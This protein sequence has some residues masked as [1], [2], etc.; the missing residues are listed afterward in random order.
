MMPPKLPGVT[1]LPAQM[2]GRPDAMQI[3]EGLVKVGWQVSVAQ[4]SFTLQGA[5]TGDDPSA[6]QMYPS[7]AAGL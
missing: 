4:S 6:R 7:H 5:P 3:G 1:A 2:I